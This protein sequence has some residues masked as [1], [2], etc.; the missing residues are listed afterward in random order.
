MTEAV[1]VHALKA[2]PHF[3]DALATGKKLFE[4]RR[5]DRHYKIGDLLQINKYDPSY[6]NVPGETPLSFEVTFVLD[7]EDFPAIMPGFVVLSLKPIG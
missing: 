1:K 3:F 4:V 2:W 7:S 5:N 6:G